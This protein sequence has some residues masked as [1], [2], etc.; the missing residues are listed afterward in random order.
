MTSP[1][2]R[3][4]QQ[5][6]KEEEPSNIQLKNTIRLLQQQNDRLEHKRKTANTPVI[7][8]DDIRDLLLKGFNRYSIQSDDY[9]RDNPRACKE[10]YRFEDWEYCKAFI[11]GMFDVEYAPPTRDS[12][13]GKMSKFEQVL[14]TLMW[15][16]SKISLQRLLLI[17]G[18]KSKSKPSTIINAWM[19]IFGEVGEHLSIL[20][21]IDKETIDE[22]EPQ[23][24]IDLELRKIGL[25]VDGKDWYAETVRQNRTISTVQQG[26]KL[27]KSSIRIL[28][29][30]M[31]FGLNVE[32]T[33]GFFARATEKHINLI[34]CKYG[35]LLVPVGYI[36]SGDKGFFGTSG[37]YV[38]FN[39]ILSPAF[40]FGKK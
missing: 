12:V 26:N 17:F 7:N 10:L 27:G 3:A 15:I 30:S 32:H 25:V 1:T 19:P 34:W 33:K 36:I 35:R 40:L 24:Y 22:L 29:W 6:N 23:S 9:H 13:N 2:T 37:F 11:E 28:T 16:E 38:N 20:P 39:H 18:Y 5:E 21:F 8:D 14:M 31:A 4:C